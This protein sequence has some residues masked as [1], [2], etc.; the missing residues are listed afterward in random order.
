[1]QKVNLLPPELAPAGISP[2]LAAVIRCCV[3]ALAVLLGAL[4]IFATVLRVEVSR[5][6]AALSKITS[7]IKESDLQAENLEDLRH[8]QRGLAKELEDVQLYLTPGLLWSKKLIQLGKIMPEEAW[9][10]KL[11]YKKGVDPAGKE[12]LNL[13]GALAPLK[14]VP[15]IDALSSFVNK[16]K[17]DKYFFGDFSELLISEVKTGKKEKIEVMEFEIR[18][19]LKANAS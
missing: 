16:L 10:A 2:D 4:L 12:S 1:M 15:F 3:F 7:K 11:S 14:D 17:A 8:K 5:K 9:L 19:I 18:L 13:S 6:R